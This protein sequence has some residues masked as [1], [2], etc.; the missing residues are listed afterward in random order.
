[1]E[2]RIRSLKEQ[3]NKRK[4]ESERLKKE[5]KSVRA[6]N[7]KAKEA[8]LLQQIRFYDKHIKLS[9]QELETEKDNLARPVQNMMKPLILKPHNK[10]TPKNANSFSLNMS[11]NMSSLE[12]NSDHTH[13]SHDY[14]KEAFDTESDKL[15]ASDSTNV[16]DKE[17]NDSLEPVVATDVEEESK[18]KIGEKTASNKDISVGKDTEVNTAIRPI[19]KL[20]ELPK[21][22]SKL[23]NEALKTSEERVVKTNSPKVPYVDS[24]IEISS[25]TD[26]I[27]EELGK[28]SRTSETASEIRTEL[29]EM[30]NRDEIVDEI[31][32]EIF[33][34]EQSMK[35]ETFV[36]EIIDPVQDMPIDGEIT[37]DGPKIKSS[38]DETINSEE[39]NSETVRTSETSQE[40]R[41]DRNTGDSIETNLEDVNESDGYEEKNAES[42]IVQ[43]SFR[44]KTVN[45]TFIVHEESLSFERTSNR[46]DSDIIE[47]EMSLSTRS[48]ESPNLKELALSPKEME[49]SQSKAIVSG[50]TDDNRETSKSSIKEKDSLEAVL[51]D[52]EESKNL[53]NPTVYEESPNESENE[54]PDEDPGVV[55]A[56]LNV[57]DVLSPNISN[58]SNIS[59]L[60]YLSLDKD[61]LQN[62]SLIHLSPSKAPDTPFLH[63]LNRDYQMNRKYQLE[64]IS[65]DI[66]SE[67]V[68][69]SIETMVTL[70]KG[71]RP[72]L[73]RAI[74]VREEDG[75]TEEVE[76]KVGEA[77][78]EYNEVVEDIESMA[79][80]V[81]EIEDADENV[82]VVVKDE[83]KDNLTEKIDLLSLSPQHQKVRINT[84]NPNPSSSFSRL[85]GVRVFVSY[86]QLALFSH[87]SP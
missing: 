53:P 42:E 18:R 25:Q 38:V 8:S 77:I 32:E 26:E 47:E 64:K 49:T 43:V 44:E 67:E 79:E 15:D 84:L 59:D 21:S 45:D 58:I 36:S 65:N 6:E 51:D 46:L 27:Q 33:S 62:Y 61:F 80:V 56:S 85:D 54:A 41:T 48:D 4:V 10:V 16:R 68:K 81:E 69:T 72:K 57:S 13:S 11:M 3:L 74:S 7:L 82:E 40:I 76:I 2:L 31:E 23:K 22:S 30:S 50:R 29:D 17:S 5:L 60:Q 70:Y 19:V 63:A 24:K 87:S 83:A 52:K 1:M 66:V 12:D 35:S 71:R 34:G 78:E 9:S 55:N 14:H 37:T 28:S 75:E 20:S 39:T 73:V 86:F